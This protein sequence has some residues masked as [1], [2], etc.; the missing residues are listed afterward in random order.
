MFKLMAKEQNLTHVTK[1]K[2][3]KEKKK[4]FATR[5]E[6]NGSQKRNGKSGGNVNEE[7]RKNEETSSIEIVDQSCRWFSA[8][9]R[10]ATPKRLSALI[11][12][13]KRCFEILNDP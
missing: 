1:K 5:R 11:N 8:N 7:A 12:S 3:K 4:K 13:A 9:D 6:P 2:K 10:L